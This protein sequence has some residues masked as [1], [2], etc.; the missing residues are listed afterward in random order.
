MSNANDQVGRQIG[1]EN[2]SS[3]F[4]FGSFVLDEELASRLRE[5]NP[6]TRLSKLEAA[7]MLS[8]LL[9]ISKPNVKQMSESEMET[10]CDTD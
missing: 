3:Y 1:R 2:K 5:E 8:G 6:G 7:P 9:A 10:T 4:C